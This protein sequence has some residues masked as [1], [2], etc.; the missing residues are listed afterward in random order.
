VL[1]FCGAGVSQAEAN[2][3]NFAVLAENVLGLLGSALDSPARRLFDAGREFEKRTGL[4]GLVATDRIFGMLEREFEP[5]E[6]REAVAIA[7]KPKVDYSLTAHR[8]MLD[9]SRTRAG[10]AR[11]VT[12]NFDLLFEDCEPGIVSS[13][14]P[15]LPDPRRE[16]D[17]RGVIH[18]HGRVESDYR[19]ACDD[20]FVLSSADFGHAYLSDGWA[21]R[22]IQALLRRFRIVFVGYSADDPPVQYLLEALNR[23]EKPSHKLYAFQSGDKTQAIAQWA[24]KGVEPIVYDS[25]NGHAALWKTLSAWAE[26]SRDVDGWHDRL[27]ASASNGPALMAPYERGMIAHVASTTTGARMLATANNPLPADWLCVFDRN[28]RYAPINGLDRYDQ[29]SPKFDPFDTF[30]LDGDTP[31]AP[32]DPDQIFKERAVPQHAWSGI[33]LLTMDC[34]N[35]S[36][37]SIAQL[38]G[39][40]AGAATNLPPRLWHLGI[41]LVRISHQPAALWWAA[42]QAQLHPHIQE[43]IEW[44]LRQNATRY[45]SAVRDGWRILLASWKQ[46]VFDRDSYRYQLEDKTKQEGWSASSVREAIDLYQPLLTVQPVNSA[47]AQQARLDLSLK[48][49][50]SVDIEYPRPHRTLEIPPENLAYATALFRQ[51]LEYAVQIEREINCHDDLYFDTTRPDDGYALDED[52]HGLTGH[53]IIF[54]KMMDL[55]IEVDRTAARE[56]FFRWSG[57]N[58]S[59]FT[60]LRIWAAGREELTT[61]EEAGQVFLDLDDDT[62]WTSRQERDLLFSLRDR[63]CELPSSVITAI[64]TRIRNGQIPWT[65]QSEDRDQLVAHYRLCRIYWLSAQ[66]VNFSFD[67]DAEVAKLSVL[68]PNWSEDSIA[69]TAQPGVSRIYSIETDTNAEPLEQIPIG[70]V[71]EE[72]LTLGQYNFASRVQRKPFCGLAKDRPIRALSVLTDAARKDI[73]VPW[74]WSSFL[75]S[76]RDIVMSSRFLSVIGRRLARLS[77]NNLMAIIHPVSAWLREH[78]ERLLSELPAI[79]DLVWN[80]A[81]EALMSAPEVKRYP[82]PD[83]VWV[84]EGLNSPAGHMVDA[85]FKDPAKITFKSRAGL[86]DSW[87]LRLKQLMNLPGDHRPHAVVMISP[88]LNWLFQT[89]PN[90]TEAQLLSLSGGEKDDSIAFWAGYLWRAQKP[91]RPLYLLLKPGFTALARQSGK[92]RNHANALAGLLLAGWGDDQDA[93]D[94]ERLITNIEMREI[95]I[96]ADDELRTQVLWYLERWTLEP[97]SEWGDRVVPFLTQVWPRQRD[98]RT[99]SVSARLADFALAIPDRFA[100]IVEAILPRLVPAHSAS[101]R[102]GS[103]LT[104]EPSSTIARRHPKALLDLL[105]A[106]LTKEAVTWPYGVDVLFS[107]LSESIETQNDPRLAEL[108]RR[109]QRR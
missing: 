3:P 25:A 98:V 21:T 92:R 49:I 74:A 47:M 87:K 46:K 65:A 36:P 17:F 97:E 15:H 33:A 62:F 2:L 7:L 9:L 22:Y 31:P 67:L 57:R 56:E 45:T 94:S 103:F 73:F 61:P 101:L 42:N 1:F 88:Y 55:L 24:H 85:L 100:D 38:C 76:E 107:Q 26:R 69:Y 48:E 52:S 35:L 32:V 102:I 77:A 60:R 4:T 80:A 27:I 34:A 83:R 59:L 10:V 70:D 93:L 30:G 89:D 40:H 5:A 72:A 37:E 75:S 11:L 86:S 43:R 96:H 108:K 14:P 68:A 104:A 95:L 81:V 105:W 23:F 29:T 58:D 44:S 64:E 50:V 54:T 8:T 28:T 82:R 51:K 78:A 109:E 20:E 12:T 19:R 39:V 84:N 18:L 91:Q 63:W 41:W 106:I 79:F 90:W 13:N 53:L 71:L 99:T 66:G 16:I 6:V